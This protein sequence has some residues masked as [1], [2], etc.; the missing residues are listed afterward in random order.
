MSLEA[1]RLVA[2][3]A[4]GV[5]FLAAAAGKLRRPAAFLEGVA[6]YEIL[7]RPLAYAFGVVVIP[8]EV[9]L[10]VS[11]LTG[12]AL[13]LAMPLALFLLLSF[14][15]AVGINL[16]RDRDLLCHCFD[17]V[18]GERISQRSLFQLLLLVA[19]E[20]FVLGD[21]AWPDLH[22]TVYQGQVAT[23]PE[24]ALALPWVVFVLVAARWSSRADDVVAMFR[25]HRC[26]SC[27]SSVSKT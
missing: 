2:Q 4:L 10:A 24:L 22:R 11:H 18:H 13:G 14:A 19:V 16:R 27:T 20:A 26:A 7:P 8:V 3:L 21:F 5:V 1:A 12:W 17:S 23:L 6:E 9:F 15:A 25:V